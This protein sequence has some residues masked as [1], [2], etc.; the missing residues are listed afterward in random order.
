MSQLFEKDG[1]QEQKWVTED[2]MVGWL[3]QPNEHEFEQT[4]EDSEGQGNMACFH[5]ITKSLTGL[6]N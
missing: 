3:H 6:C 1:G 5:G 2:E 4:L